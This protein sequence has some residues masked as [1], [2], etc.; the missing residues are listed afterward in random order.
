MITT[1]KNAP[2]LFTSNGLELPEGTYIRYLPTLEMV[3]SE[4]R[5]SIEFRY[6]VSVEAY[7]QGFVPLT[8]PHFVVDG[9]KRFMPKNGV[10]KLTEQTAPDIMAAIGVN[11]TE[12]LPYAAMVFGVTEKAFHYMAISLLQET[13]GDGTIS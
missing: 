7:E 3:G 9:A 6:F 8:P 12:P 11:P 4:V 13:L 1:S 10:W 2:T 5:I